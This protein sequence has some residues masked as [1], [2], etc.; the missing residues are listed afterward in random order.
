MKLYEKYLIT[1]AITASKSLEK[2]KKA[3]SDI[4]SPLE[5]RMAKGMIVDF[6]KKFKSYYTDSVSKE[7]NDLLMVA[8]RKVKR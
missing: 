6:I 1:E 3:L 7:L 4:S 5:L 2:L 8:Q